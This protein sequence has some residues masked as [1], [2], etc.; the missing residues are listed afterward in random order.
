[1]SDAELPRKPLPTPTLRQLSCFKE[2][3]THRSFSRAA[4]VSTP[5]VIWREITPDEQL[6]MPKLARRVYGDNAEWMAC[7]AVCG[8]EVPD[9]PARL[10]RY[11]F[12]DRAQ[13]AGIKRQVGF[14][15]QPEF[16]NADGS[17]SWGSY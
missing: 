9:M 7:A 4:R 11:A 2:V 8:V 6:D 5:G 17:P 10:G 14:E 1:M 12:P 15:T 3:A 16:R 13:L